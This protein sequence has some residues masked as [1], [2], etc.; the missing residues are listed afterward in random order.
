MSD[1]G[2]M[3]AS[4]SWEVGKLEKDRWS[5]QLLEETPVWLQPGLSSEHHE[6]GFSSLG[7]KPMLLD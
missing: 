2:W 1:I 7:P 6:A 5:H 4:E 3:Q